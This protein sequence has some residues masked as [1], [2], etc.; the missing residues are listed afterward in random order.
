MSHS[1]SNHPRPIP[2]GISLVFLLLMATLPACTVSVRRYAFN[3]ALENQKHIDK[4]RIGQTLSEVERIMG[5]GP[6]RRNAHVRFDSISIEEWSYITD[7]VRRMDTTITFVGGKV[8]E[9]RAAQ[10]E[11]D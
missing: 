8:D 10:W 9:I 4:L 3:A 2:A 5:K 11:S 6:E 1:T 7:Y